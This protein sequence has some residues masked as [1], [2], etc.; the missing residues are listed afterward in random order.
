MKC[1][2]LK[3]RQAQIGWNLEKRRKNKIKASSSRSDLTFSHI[4]E[5]LLIVQP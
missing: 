4:L 5:T 1:G 2:N 3:K